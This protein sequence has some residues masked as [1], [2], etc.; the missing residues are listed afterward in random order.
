MLVRV[1]ERRP[2]QGAHA[3]V[4]D[5]KPLVAVLLRARDLADQG[6]G[7]GDHGPP[8]LD[9]ERQ[10]QVGDLLPDGG[11]QLGGGRQRRAAARVVDAQPAADVEEAQAGVPL[12]PDLPDELD[13]RRGRI[14]EDVHLR[15]RGA[16]VGVDAGQV[17]APVGGDL[18][19]EPRE[20][21]VADAELGRREA[22][23]DVGVDLFEFFF[24]PRETILSFF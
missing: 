17:E 10:A 15:D 22:R 24:A 18:P 7:G 4:D 11:D 14:A 12:A 20:L 2:D 1:V 3:A 13:H 9:D 19:E 8:R 21:R 5:H 23:R 6:A 16:Q